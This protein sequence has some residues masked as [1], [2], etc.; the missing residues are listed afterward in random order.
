MGTKAKLLG[1]GLGVPAA[2]A[3]AQAP[4]G[5]PG[6]PAVS[7]VAGEEATASIQ[8]IVVTAQ[9]R[10]E[11]LQ[12]SSL[13]ISVVD[14]AALQRMG[15][16]QAQDLTTTTPGL[17]VAQ[18]GPLVQTYIRGVGDSSGNPT[19]V[20]PVAYNIDGVY[21]ARSE[22]IGTNFYDLERIEVLKGPQ[23]T[24]YGRNA[25]G[26]A[27]N[28]ITRR[29]TL[30]QFDGHASLEIGNFSARRLEGG[31]NLPL[32]PTVALR[33]AGNLVRRD[34]YL[35][36]GTSDD[37][38]TAG[39][40][41]LLWQPSPAVSLLLNT[42]FAHIG[43]I[44]GGFVYLPRRPGS[45][46]REGTLDPRAQQYLLSFN[47]ALV[48]SVRPFQDGDFA[49]ASAEFNADLGFA[50]MTVLP[51][52][53][54]VKYQNF[55]HSGFIVGQATN[56][57]QLSLEARLS[58]A[59]TALKWVAGLY[60]FREKQ[61]AQTTIIASPFIQDVDFFFHPDTRSYAAFGEATVTI[62]DSLRAIGGLR[63][64]SDRRKMTGVA[65]DHI[66]SL[67]RPFAGGKR[68]TRVTWKAGAEYDLSDR[69]MLFAT[70]STGFKS[71]GVNQEVAPNI[72]RP[73]KLTA[74]EVGS[75]NRFLDNRL[76]VN[77]ELFY[78]KY[79]DHQETT[80]TLDNS[81]FVN[82]RVVNAGKATIKGGNI[83]IVA[84]PTANGTLRAS[85]EYTD[86]VYGQ[87]AFPTI[88]SAFGIQFFD[89]RSTGCGIGPAVAGPLPGSTGRTIDCS[90]KRLP[91]APKWS[92]NIGYDHSFAISDRSKIVL[93]V[94]MQLASWRWLWTSFNGSSRASGYTVANA[95]A[96][97][98]TADDR[99]SFTAFVRNLND[100]RAYQ[101]GFTNPYVANL[102]AATINPPRQY[103]G[104][105]SYKF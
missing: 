72:Y 50:T 41:R 8:D 81:F 85:L 15:V 51:A 44:G 64:T 103:G 67:M 31:M 93:S 9:R 52:Y 92:G 104:R 73:E 6:M 76:Q 77:V 63:Y 7:T 55:V 61:D 86:A 35:S 84:R 82:L 58:R 19:A 23:G 24:L 94:D 66:L 87:F 27:I 96:S 30:D 17:Q 56:S 49:N 75:R 102:F 39:R 71:G 98:V 59:G 105:V 2:V 4:V 33:V 80:I 38:Q 28:L 90:G 99:L 60:Y 14:G 89:P 91:R 83:D 16:S 21:I 45:G 29:P 40:A 22:S 65:D 37:R 48:P 101:G 78:W 79:D 32:G 10:S 54:H 20:S 1:L 70:A 3:S 74:F 62:T 34:G 53:R 97:F 26:G 88:D 43:G 42:D 47:P 100:G 36:D 57:D 69:N 11:N 12:R 68:F 25:S 46:A 18:Y 5:N 95:S 13:A